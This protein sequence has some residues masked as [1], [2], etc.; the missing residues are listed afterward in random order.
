MLILSNAKESRLTENETDLNINIDGA[1]I[2]NTAQEKLLD[3]IID[4]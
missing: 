3:V 2:K 1:Q 4:K